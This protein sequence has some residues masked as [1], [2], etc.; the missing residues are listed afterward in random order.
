MGL[1]RGDRGNE[2]DGGREETHGAGQKRCN[3]D[4]NDRVRLMTGDSRQT[5]KGRGDGEAD[6]RTLGRAESGDI[7]QGAADG[8]PRR[9]CK[10]AELGRLEVELQFDSK[11]EVR[12][13]SLVGHLSM[14]QGHVSRM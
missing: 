9:G 2:Q 6:S 4:D 13:E 12:Y 10:T 8:Q 5:R 14:C 3:T 1:M 7:W 11:K